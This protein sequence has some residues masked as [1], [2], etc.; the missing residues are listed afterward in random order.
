[1]RQETGTQVIANCGLQSVGHGHKGCLSYPGMEGCM[2]KLQ[3]CCSDLLAR[4]PLSSA[5]SICKS[6]CKLFL[7]GLSYRIFMVHS[8]PKRISGSKQLIN[9]L[10]SARE[11]SHPLRKGIMNSNYSMQAE[12]GYFRLKCS[13]LITALLPSLPHKI[14]CFMSPRQS[15][16]YRSTCTL[17]KVSLR[18]QVHSQC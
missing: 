17:H 2:P 4:A 18:S 1:M 11:K 15:G 16:E 8:H 3:H 12:N 14:K 9:L 5:L 10:S 7:S 6:G 13:P